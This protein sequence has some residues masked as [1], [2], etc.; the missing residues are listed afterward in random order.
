MPGIFAVD[1]FGALGG[2]FAIVET[3][4]KQCEAKEKNVT[5][6]TPACWTYCIRLAV[7]QESGFSGFVGKV[8]A[9]LVFTTLAS[10]FSH[11]A[12]KPCSSTTQFIVAQRFE[13]RSYTIRVFERTGLMR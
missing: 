9:R 13:S 8:A 2:L 4:T 7:S 6:L 5:L 1:S 11:V 10:H 12:R 3:G